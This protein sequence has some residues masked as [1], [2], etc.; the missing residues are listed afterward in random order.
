MDRDV[1]AQAFVESIVD[2]GEISLVFFDGVYSHAARKVPQP[3][4]FRVQREFGGRLEIGDVASEVIDEASRVLHQAPCV[5]S[6]ARVDGVMVEGRFMLME[7]ELIEPELYL[8]EV[9]S[10]PARF[11][12]VIASAVSRRP[13]GGR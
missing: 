1:I 6:Y 4:D 2:V 9:A 5:P 10:A 12:A 8:A 7:L 11:A 13:A 3:G